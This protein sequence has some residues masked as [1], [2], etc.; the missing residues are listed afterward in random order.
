MNSPVVFLIYNRPELTR[1]AFA[2]IRAAK[3]R[4]LVVV[5]DGPRAGDPR[6]AERCATTRSI[7]ESIDW[8]CDLRTDFADTNLGCTARVSSGITRAL[9]TFDRAVILE[10]DC[11]ADPSFFRFA[12]EMLDRYAA[13]ERIFSVTGDNF[14]FGRRVTPD[15]YFFS[16]Y[17]YCWGWATWSRAWKHYDV[18][19]RAWPQVRDGDFLESGFDGDRS[20][21]RYWRLVLDRTYSRVTDTWD[22][23]WFFTCWMH[24]A[25]T[26]VPETNLVTNIG[27]IRQATHTTMRMNALGNIASQPLSFPLR[28]PEAVE[29]NDAADR[30]IEKRVFEH[31]RLLW[32]DRILSR[33]S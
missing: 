19:M 26:V 32:L 7:V 16:R 15:S 12:D 28:H 17:P 29:R 18:A 11:V 20:A 10:D 25:L 22:F 2:P 14:L 4:T 24:R 13:D 31:Q 27:F 1:R 5:A 23:P 33:K 6:D 21:I 3:P 8:P 30:H 9:E